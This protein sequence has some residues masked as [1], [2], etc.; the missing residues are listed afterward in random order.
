MKIENGRMDIVSR[1]RYPKD[2]LFR[3]VVSNGEVVLS[4]DNKG[5][6]FY[7][8][9]SVSSIIIFFFKKP[10][11]RYGRISREDELREELLRRLGNH[12]C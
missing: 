3:F 6:G 5:R 10:Y 7:L 8:L 4:D 1:K 11:S 9:R 2:M 12:G